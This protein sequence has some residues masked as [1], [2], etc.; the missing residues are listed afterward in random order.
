MKLLSFTLI[1]LA[2]ICAC[3]STHVSSDEVT[4]SINSGTSVFPHEDNWPKPENHGLTTLS[5]FSMGIDNAL[6]SSCLPCH[7]A[8]SFC[9]ECHADF[10]HDTSWLNTNSSDFHGRSDASCTSQCHGEDLNGGLSDIACTSC[11]Q[12]YPHE[13]TNNNITSY[14]NSE[15]TQWSDYQ[16]H[17]HYV[18]ETNA[19]EKGSCATTCHGTDLSGGASAVACSS[20]HNTYPHNMFNSNWSLVHQ[21]YVNLAGDQSC[22]ATGGCHTSNNQGPDT[23][24][25]SCTTLCHQSP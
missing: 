1:L 7:E 9:H 25:Q 20:C 3:S 17:G 5:L 15:T 16:A 22:G 24:V 11:H 2:L 8:Q 10:P 21:S 19:L 12:N 4:P 23:V 13:T 18:S 6:A 14:F